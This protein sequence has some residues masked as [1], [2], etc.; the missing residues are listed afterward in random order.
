[1][2]SASELLK[3]SQQKVRRLVTVTIALGSFS[4]LLIIAETWFLAKVVDGAIFQSQTLQDLMPWLWLMLLVLFFRVVTV[5][6][7]EQFAFAAATRV[8]RDLR[9]RLFEKIQ[10]LGPLSLGDQ[11]SGSYS[12]VIV[13]GVEAVE[14]Y[15]ARYLPAV[16]IAVWVPAAILLFV[17]PL[18]WK[19]AVVFVVTAPLIPFFMILIGKGTEKLNQKQ[20]RVLTRMGGRFLDAI[21]GLTTLKLFNASKRELR[22]IE[23]ISEDYRLATMKVLRLA[24]LSSLALEF[25][26]TVSIALVA[27]LIGFRLFYN[28]M[29]FFTGFYILLL[30]PEF[31]LPL[32]NMGTHYHGRMDA[33]AAAENMHELMTQ[34]A[35][36]NPSNIPSEIKPQLDIPAVPAIR[37][38]NVSLSYADRNAL[39]GCS[40]EI[41]AGEQVALV[42]P[43]GAGKTSVINLLLRFAQPQQGQ[44][45]VSEFELQHLDLNAWRK[46]IAWVPQQPRIFHGSIA[47]NL[48][49]GLETISENQ[50]REALHQAN[51]LEFV[52]RLPAGMH[53][54]VGEAGQGLSG[55]QIQRL[56]LAR[57]WLRDAG[58]LILDEPT[59]HLDSHT[60]T[61]VQQALERLKKG[62]TVMTVAHRLSTIQ[63]ADRIVVIENGQVVEQG[64]HQQLQQNDQSLYQRLLSV[65]VSDQVD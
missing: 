18:D 5:Y 51:A 3:Q 13:E 17:L 15:F 36:E 44:I 26:A 58:L 42:G 61:L 57:V 49:L 23:T 35:D 22:V 21:Q 38:E 41:K 46:R 50:I 20:W 14:N 9:S 53:T 62:K 48:C 43:S 11:G 4:G 32:R 60:Q 37:F 7:S 2:N 24:F 63:N 45:Y 30:A 47:D 55:G 29:D 28:E 54:L 56:A 59:A 33:L 31:Y 65:A 25:F 10:N 1:M 27:V 12:S 64:S 52:E 34:Q 19:S 16:A 39:K 40:F 6:L 8:K